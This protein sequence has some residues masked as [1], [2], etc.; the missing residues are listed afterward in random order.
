MKC[1]LNT[2]EFDPQY[3][4][5]TKQ[6]RILRKQL[7]TTINLLKVVCCLTLMFIGSLLIASNKIDD[8]TN[9]ISRLENN[10]IL[11]KDE[12]STL[13]IKNEE[14]VGTFN[15]L[16]ETL[17]TTFDMIVELDES[18][19]TLKQDNHELQ[20]IISKYEERAELFDKYEYAIIRDNGT[21]TDITY[22]NIKNLEQL[23]QEKEMTEETV[24][25]VLSLA[26]T[27]SNGKE[28]VNNK[29]STARGYGQ[30]L[31]ST[32]E[33]VYC[34]LMDNS[35]YSHELAY[36]GDTNFAMMVN[37]LD[38]LNIKNRGNMTK[39]IDGY[40]GIESDDYKYKVDGYLSKAGLE[41]NT[42][43]LR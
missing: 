39:V 1:N 22:D 30:I 21:R 16:S 11:L 15:Y 18:N 19:N 3:L 40:R 17:K 41:L 38:Y 32:G 4:R 35:S 13:A 31:S 43:C 37:Y 20:T 12:I 10:S 7:K 28:K 24:D 26:M 23:V 36:D 42:L 29:T 14:L 25:L 34:R 8:L 5:L 6:N 33:F 27:E 9:E 2:N